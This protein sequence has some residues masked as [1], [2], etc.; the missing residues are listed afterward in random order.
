MTQVHDLFDDPIAVSTN[1]LVILV[2]KGNP[3]QIRSLKD[4]GKPGVRLGVGHEKQ[5][6]LKR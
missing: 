3:L 1:Q 6:A 4:L 2:R 5:C